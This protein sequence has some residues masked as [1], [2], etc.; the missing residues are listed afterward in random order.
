MIC[1]VFEIK[2]LGCDNENE[3]FSQKYLDAPVVFNYNFVNGT[4][5]TKLLCKLNENEF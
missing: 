5:K 2:N 4:Y 3:L 1:Q